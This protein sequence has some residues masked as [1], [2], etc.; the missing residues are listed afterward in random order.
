MA[1]LAMG[2]STVGLL[3]PGQVTFHGMPSVYTLT[4]DIAAVLRLEGIGRRSKSIWELH[5][6]LSPNF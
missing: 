5:G 2:T 1:S 6:P 4:P 3:A